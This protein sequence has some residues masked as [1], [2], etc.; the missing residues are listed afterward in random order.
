MAVDRLE[1]MQQCHSATA[2]MRSSRACQ[3]GVTRDK[4]FACTNFRGLGLI[5]KNSK[6]LSQTKINTP[7]VRILS[8]Y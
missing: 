5:C 6:N 4:Y 1:V 3:S 7:M 8:M 2:A